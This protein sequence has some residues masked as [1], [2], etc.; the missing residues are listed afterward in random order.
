[1]LKERH[2][3]PRPHPLCAQQV[4]QTARVFHIVL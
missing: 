2:M 4:C 1:M 3:Q